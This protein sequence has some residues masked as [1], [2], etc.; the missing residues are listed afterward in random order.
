MS[1]FSNFMAPVWPGSVCIFLFVC[2]F[3]EGGVFLS[4]HCLGRY[5]WMDECCFVGVVY[6]WTGPAVV[7]VVSPRWSL[8]MGNICSWCRHAL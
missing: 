3:G 6:M 5:G 7:V 1:H 2:L 4:P 8:G